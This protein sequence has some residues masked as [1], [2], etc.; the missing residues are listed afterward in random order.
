MLIFQNP[1]F[2]K[3]SV[4]RHTRKKIFF[5]VDLFSVF[6]PSIFVCR[7]PD[8]FKNPRSIKYPFI[9]MAT[10]VSSYFASISGKHFIIFHP[11]FWEPWRVWTGDWLYVWQTPWC[12]FFPVEQHNSFWKVHRWDF[13]TLHAAW[14]GE[15]AGGLGLERRAQSQRCLLSTA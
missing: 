3:T 12:V 7:I 4:I 15:G 14:P 5:E 13:R 2:Y 9:S 1:T 6:F 8:Y 11:V 10:E